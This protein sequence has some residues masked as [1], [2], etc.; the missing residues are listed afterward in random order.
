V[1]L[2]DILARRLLPSRIYR[3][4]AASDIAKRLARGSAWS[5]LGSATSRLLLL[6]GM[7][8]LA[9]ILGQTEFGEFGMVQATLGVAGMMAG[10]GLGSTATRFVAQYRKTDPARAGRVIALVTLFSWGL[11]LVV[12]LLIALGAGLIARD[13]LNA[14][15]LQ[16]SLIWGTLLMVA[17]TIRG[18]QSGVLAGVERFDVIAKLNV[19]EGIISLVGLVLLAWLFGVEGGLLGLALSIFA[20]WLAGRY[21]V[22]S[23]LRDLNISITPKGC[24]QEKKI[25]TGYSLPSFLA[26]SVATPVLWYCMT[27]VAKRADGYDDLA[28]Y[29][30]AYQWH[31]PLMFLPMILLSVSAPVLVQQWEQGSFRQF[32]K[33]FLWNAGFMLVISAIPVLLIALLSPWI[34]GLY[35]DGFGDGWLLLILLVS[36]APIHAM[37]KMASTALF[38]MNR[39]WSV[40]GLNVIWGATMFLLSTMLVSAMGASGLVIAFLSAYCV[41]MST[42][43]VLVFWHLRQADHSEH[44]IIEKSI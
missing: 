26:S 24:W 33:I 21:A 15:H 10:F 14:A 6:A 13:A 20:T 38:G 3:G 39:A 9:R 19:L 7:I 17:M 36:A 34:M 22:Q 43:I 37:A 16:T 35:G 40:F 25:L 27:L 30:A 31:G 42:A 5:V 11:I 44:F 18:V 23:T 28:L 1:S 8:L 41:L 2:L 29:N 4:F 12:G 32:R